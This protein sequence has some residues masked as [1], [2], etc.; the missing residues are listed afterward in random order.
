M[1]LARKRDARAVNGIAANNIQYLRVFFAGGFEGLLALRHVVKEI[2]DLIWSAK[3][4]LENHSTLLLS[5][6]QV[7]RPSVSGPGSDLAWEAPIYRPCSRLSKHSW[8]RQF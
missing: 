6:C 4:T 5:E 8:I 1:L 7:C 3:V 2:L